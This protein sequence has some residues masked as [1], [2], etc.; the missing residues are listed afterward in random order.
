MLKKGKN[1]GVTLVEVLVVLAIIIILAS[2]ILKLA[3]RFEDRAGERKT[4]AAI[5]VIDAALHE[6]GEFKY[7]YA[8]TYDPY[9]YPIDCTDFTANEVQNELNLATDSI[10]VINAG[11]YD[12][13]YSG[14]S[15]MYF[16]LDQVPGCSEILENIDSELVTDEDVDGNPME[17]EV[18]GRT[19][20]YYRVVDAWGKTLRYDYY[21]E[22]EG[23]DQQRF[24][25]RRNFPEV[26][27]AG[28]NGVFEPDD[29][30]SDDITSEMFKK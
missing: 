2:M 23:N 25:E 28:K 27:S 12:T 14:C 26:R 16:L 6:F 10:Y 21:D 9:E 1:T 11:V 8:Q 22:T 4:R 17:I 24:E 30:K 7:N 29:P 13:E 15:V 20:P 19:Y 5:S 3:S 18:D